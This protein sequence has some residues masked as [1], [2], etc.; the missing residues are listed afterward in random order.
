MLVGW[1]VP[2]LI[3]FDDLSSPFDPFQSNFACPLIVAHVNEMG[4]MGK[5]IFTLALIKRFL[6][7]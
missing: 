2:N 7:F 4:N 6:L 1:L 5:W 3:S